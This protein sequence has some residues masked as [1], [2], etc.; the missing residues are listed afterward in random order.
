MGVLRIK[1]ENL[2][3]VVREPLEAAENHLGLERNHLVRPKYLSLQRTHGPLNLLHLLE[4]LGSAGRTNTRPVLERLCNVI[5]R[6]AADV[7]ETVHTLQLRVQEHLFGEGIVAGNVQGGAVHAYA[8]QDLD[9]VIE[10]LVEV[11]GTGQRDVSE[12]A[13]TL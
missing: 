6:A 4:N 10:E 8:V 7:G 3:S 5:N 2:H 13:L 9:R 1:A 12:M 11:D